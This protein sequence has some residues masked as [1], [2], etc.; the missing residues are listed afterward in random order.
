[1]KT[2]ILTA[3][4][5]LMCAACSNESE[6]TVTNTQVEQNLTAPVM[7]HVDGFQT[8]QEEFPGAPRRAAQTVASY[9]NVGAMTL[10]F[11]SGTTE[12]YKTTQIKSDN[13]TYTTFGD[14]SLTLPLG[15]YT[16]VVLAYGYFD[17]DVLNLTSPTSAVYDSDHVRETLVATQAVNVTNTNAM[18]LSATLTR[19]VSEL[20]IQSTDGRTAN[21][22]NLRMT[23]SKGGKSFNPTTGLATSNT[24]FSNT[25]GTTTPVGNI[26]RSMGFLFLDSDEQTMDVTIELLNAQGTA[27]TQKVVTDVPFKRNRI[28]KLTGPLYSASSSS[29]FL[30]ETEWIET[31]EKNF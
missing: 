1:M 27:I 6:E 25:V 5:V 29:S 10:A 12:V 24:G 17:G 9:N 15:S 23:F 26:T 31:Y 22:T 3:A 14:F 16:M 7:V 28:T 2:V 18:E 21:V 11:Y 4:A 8:S 13:S 19:V 20:Q 30:L